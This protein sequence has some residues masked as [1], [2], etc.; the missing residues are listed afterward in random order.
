MKR[1]M[2][3]SVGGGGVGVPTQCMLLAVSLWKY[4]S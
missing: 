3:V 4:I 1:S 2:D